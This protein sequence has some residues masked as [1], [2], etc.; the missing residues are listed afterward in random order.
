MTDEYCFEWLQQEPERHIQPDLRRGY[1]DFPMNTC[2]L[3]TQSI[4][5]P[6]TGE[7]MLRGER[8]GRLLYL[9]FRL[10]YWQ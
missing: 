3:K 7:I 6:F 5:M 4:A 2:T 10:L 1:I 9:S 8:I